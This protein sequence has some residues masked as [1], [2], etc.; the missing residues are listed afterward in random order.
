MSSR[1]RQ[2]NQRVDTADQPAT[3]QRSRQVGTV[4][5][6]MASIMPLIEANKT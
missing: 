1:L 6:Q 2:G 4:G 5:E 3:R